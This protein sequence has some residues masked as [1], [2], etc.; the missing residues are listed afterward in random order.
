MADERAP[1]GF[2]VQW[3]HAVDCPVVG[4]ELIPNTFPLAHSLCECGMPSLYEHI[5]LTRLCVKEWS[6]RCREGM[7]DAKGSTNPA[8][9]AEATRQDPTPPPPVDPSV[10]KCGTVTELH[11]KGG[12][13]GEGEK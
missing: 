3:I 13:D 7:Q 10:R 5:T 2:H 1:G 9:V 6:A 11:P 12:D 8:L 4:M